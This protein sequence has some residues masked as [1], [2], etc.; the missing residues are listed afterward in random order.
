MPLARWSPFGNTIIA[1]PSLQHQYQSRTAK[2]NVKVRPAAVTHSY[3]GK[4]PITSNGGEG[5]YLTDTAL[6]APVL[7]GA[8]HYNNF[9]PGGAGFPSAGGSYTDL[10]FGGVV[11]RLTNT[12]TGTSA[13]QDNIYAKHWANANGTYAFH[14]NLDGGRLVHILDIATGTFLWTDQP[15]GVEAFEIFWDA[16]DPD[17]YYYLSGA[18]I[19]RRNLAAQTDTTIHTFGGTLQDLGG[20]HNF[21]SADGRYFIVQ[22]AGQGWVWDSQLNLEY[23]GHPNLLGGGDGWMTLSPDGNYL[24]TA[25]G[26]TA[27]P[28]KEH[29]SFAINHT[30]HVVSTTPTQF[31]GL[32]GDHMA[33]VSASDG[34]N[35][36]I[37][38]NCTS[39]PAGGKIHRVDITL[40]QAGR[41][42]TQQTNDSQVILDI[43]TSAGW[44]LDM[45]AS[46]SIRG[47]N[48]DWCFISVENNT[49]ADPFNGGV[50]SFKRYWQEIVGVNVV[51][52]E[53]RRFCHHRSRGMT[54]NIVAYQP[55]VS[56]SWD[57]S[58]VMWASN[59]NTSTPSDYEDLYY[60]KPN[61]S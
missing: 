9:K 39:D 11:H 24:V 8:Q 5:T 37:T 22:I 19:V 57:G 45:H 44:N 49:G 60:I 34:K 23:T 17:K 61:L 52:L 58:V 40:N 10:I 41:T 15:N 32:C 3:I 54:G 12:L 16:L 43:D 35:Y 21:Q 38:F 18:S 1:A 6:H 33:L 51:T 25:A 47:A 55:R 53:V 26:G 42:V 50:G 2:V 31:W 28:Q 30:T 7:S 56:T 4:I 36:A 48:R 46:G 14:Q 20:T 27:M 29:Y 13:N 59:F